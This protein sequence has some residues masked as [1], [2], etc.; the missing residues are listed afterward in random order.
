M[1][2][3]FGH[4]DS[5]H[6]YKVRFFMVAAGIEHEY[7]VVDIFAPRDQRQAEFM[8]HARYHEVPLLLDGDKA[9]VQSGALLLY[10]AEQTN[11][12]GAQNA[13]LW[14]QCREW[15]VWESNKIGLCLPQLLAHEKFESMRLNEGAHQWLSQRYDHDSKLL[16]DAL[17]DQRPF[18][19]GDEPSIADFCL[20][21][22]LFMAEPSSI[23]A[24]DRVS[25]WLGRLA[26]LPGW[27]PPSKLLAG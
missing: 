24:P 21:G 25:A 7:E 18:I 9:L 16:N 13:K 23:E 14:Q 11:R 4:P 10:L 27:Q 3:L 15:I 20:S 6:A 8:K 12:W 1:K 19:L 17:A 5:G 22:Y 2:K 26:K